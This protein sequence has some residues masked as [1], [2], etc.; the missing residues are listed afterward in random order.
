MTWSVKYLPPVFLADFFFSFFIVT[1]QN[2]E[3]HIQLCIHPP[4][5][6]KLSINANVPVSLAAIHAQAITEPLSC[7]T[8][9]LSTYFIILIEIDFSLVHRT[10]FH[11]STAAQPGVCLVINSLCSYEDFSIISIIDKD[12]C[13]SKSGGVL[14]MCS[15]CK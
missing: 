6:V 13:K 11:N 2:D 5:A 15:P 9:E 7:L 1:L 8:N 14:L 12:T 10:L 3:M 4:S